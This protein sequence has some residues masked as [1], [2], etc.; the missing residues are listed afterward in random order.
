MNYWKSYWS[1]QKDGGHRSQRESFLQKE[2]REKL[3]HLGSGETLLDVGCGS[4]DL[5]VYY[6]QHFK[7][8]VGADFSESM[9]KNARKRIE[10][11]R[12]SNVQLIKADVSLIWSELQEKFD[13]VTTAEVFQYL[14]YSQIRQFIKKAK[15]TLNPGGK[16]II[17][18]VID[19][20]IYFIWEVGLFSQDTN[21]AR[22][23]KNLILTTSHQLIRKFHSKPPREI[24]YTHHP[25]RI[26]KFAEENDLNMEY[27]CSMYYEYRYHLILTQGILKEDFD[28]L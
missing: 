26:K 12:L 15:L 22:L 21:F 2:A 16:I 20:R 11:F 24:G 23:A 19:P 10:A 13:R 18:D 25:Q 6:A 3:Y 8:V 4:A 27:V 5:L 9:L 14:K 28:A 1:T 7:K 17:F